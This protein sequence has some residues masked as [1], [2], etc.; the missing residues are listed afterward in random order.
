M[1]EAIEADYRRQ[2][3]GLR[4]ELGEMKDRAERAEQDRDAVAFV[5]CASLA[6]LERYGYM[7]EDLGVLSEEFR[8][9]RVMPVIE[10]ARAA[11]AAGLPAKGA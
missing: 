11:I 6:A 10:A 1:N 9:M 8:Q 3:D 2:I 4:R 5:A 7:R